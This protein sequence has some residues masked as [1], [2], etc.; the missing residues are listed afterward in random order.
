[1]LRRAKPRYWIWGL[2][3]LLLVGVL[4]VFGTKDRIERDLTKR[5][6]AALSD[7]GITWATPTF[8]GLDGLIEGQAPS[9][10]ER[11]KAL[12]VVSNVW[13]VRVV[14]D[15]LLLAPKISPYVWNGRLSKGRIIL[16]GYVP[17]MD[18]KQS[19]VGLATAKFPQE[20]LVEEMK[21]GSGSED[22]SNWFGKVSFGLSQLARTKHGEVKIQ[23]G[24]FNITC[25]AL[26]EAGFISLNETFNSPLPLNMTKGSI[27][28]LPPVVENYF[29]T[30]RSDQSSLFIEG[31]VTDEAQK[32]KVIKSAKELFPQLTLQNNIKLGS[33]APKGWAKAVQLSLTE[34]AKLDEGSVTLQGLTAKIE[35][36]AE[37]KNIANEV[38]KNVRSSYPTGF[39]VDDTINIKK[40]ELPVI[41]PFETKIRVENGAVFLSG[42][43]E[44]EEQKQE[45]ASSLQETF[46]NLKLNNQ[47]ELGKGSTEKYLDA[48]K[49]GIALLPKLTDAQLLLS[50]DQLSIGGSSKDQEFVTNLDSKPAGLAEEFSWVNGVQYDDSDVRAEEEAAKLQAEKEAAEKEAA[51]KAEA[52]KLAAEKAEAEKL[53]AEKEAAE[54]AAAEKLAAEQAEAENKEPVASEEELAKKRK[55]LT[56]EQTAQRLVDLHKESGAVNAK[57]CQLLMNSIVRGS[58]I[59]FGVN[60]SVINASSYDVLSKVHSVASRCTNTVIRVEGHT[61]SDGSDEYNLELSKRRAQSVV[62]YLNKLGIPRIRLDT[63]GYGEKK[64]VAS[65]GTS[66]GKGLNRRIEF[67]VFEN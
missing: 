13:G 17:T 18:V 10:K 14:S 56:P 3:L 53:A 34:L 67:I 4:V 11:L 2:F 7:A 33:G 21:L 40:P 54:K 58:A 66:S 62:T 46:P 6:V 8:T 15:K 42:Y 41:S 25:A 38:R 36:T 26:D 24:V 39:K 27:T 59:R 61:D 52:E 23:D 45:L 35:G 50:D 57:E 63:K 37:N 12:K 51:L 29:L 9:E 64:P 32:N 5:S 55:W 65:N 20:R 30:L 31:V 22:D 49:V 1:M 48:I 16:G 19:V 28:I 44:T 43:V 60:S 47:L